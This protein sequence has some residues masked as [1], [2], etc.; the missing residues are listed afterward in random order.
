M[1]DRETAHRALVDRVVRGPGT[2]TPQQRET[3]FANAGVDPA[4]QPLIG[5]VAADP[6]RITDADFDRAR[7]AGFTEDQLFEMVIAAAVGQS[8]RLYE[9]ARAALDEAVTG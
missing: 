8:T 5:K 2:T 9:S 7:A 6:T 4:L 3:A 1:D